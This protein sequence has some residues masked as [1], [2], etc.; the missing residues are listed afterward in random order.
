MRYFLCGQT[1]MLSISK[2]TH[3]NHQTIHFFAILLSSIKHIFYA[4]LYIIH[5]ILR[6][7]NL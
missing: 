5:E 4:V 3:K 6:M 7:Y 1:I 2:K